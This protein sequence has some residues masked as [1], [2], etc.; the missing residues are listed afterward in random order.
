MQQLKLPVRAGTRGLA[1]P[2]SVTKIY[3]ETLGAESV[4][5]MFLSNLPRRFQMANLP[6]VAASRLAMR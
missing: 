6:Q 2:D 1:V 3:G 5:V 4:V